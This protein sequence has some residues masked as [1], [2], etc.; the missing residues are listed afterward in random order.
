MWKIKKGNQS[1]S[2][3]FSVKLCAEAISQ[4]YTENHEVS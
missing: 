4:S 1:I 2:L 3:W